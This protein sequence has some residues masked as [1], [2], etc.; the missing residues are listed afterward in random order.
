MG[1]LNTTWQEGQRVLHRD[2]SYCCGWFCSLLHW[3]FSVFQWYFSTCQVTRR[4]RADWSAMEGCFPSIPRSK[5]CL[6]GSQFQAYQQSLWQADAIREDVK[7]LG[8]HKSK[9]LKGEA[10]KGAEGG[11]G[12]HREG[13]HLSSW[14]GYDD[15]GKLCT[16]LQARQIRRS[17]RQPAAHP[18]VIIWEDLGLHLPEDHWVAHKG[19]GNL[20]GAPEGSAE[21]KD[22]VV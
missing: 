10:L 13:F 6:Q 14:R 5:V 7:Q 18:P 1:S 20:L 15:Q 4:K 3:Y 16:H 11:G 19:Q 22:L 9:E 17:K 12:I 8:M 21:E 2:T